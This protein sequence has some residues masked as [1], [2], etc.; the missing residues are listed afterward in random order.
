VRLDED[1]IE[2]KSTFPA[3]K[4]V[5]SPTLLQISLGDDNVATVG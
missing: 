1:E 4:A 2:T 3:R 5:A